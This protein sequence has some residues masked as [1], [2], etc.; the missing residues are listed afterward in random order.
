MKS[1][2][3]VAVTLSNDLLD[4]LHHVALEVDVPLRWVV[5][6][7]VCDTVEALAGRIGLP[8]NGE[9]SESPVTRRTGYGRLGLIRMPVSGSR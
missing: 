2:V 5:A 3:E 8:N 6:G 4:R 1:Q 7:L 9:R